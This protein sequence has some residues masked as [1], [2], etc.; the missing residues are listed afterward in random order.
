[1]TTL[2]ATIYRSLD[3]LRRRSGRPIRYLAA[4]GFNAALGLTFYP[5]LLWLFPYF[6]THYLVALLIA[7][8]T[9]TVI[10]FTVYKL[11][12]FRSQGNLIRE[13]GS[14]IVFYLLNYMVNWALL[15]VMVEYFHMSPIIAQW[16]FVILLAASSY[17]WHSRISFRLR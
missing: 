11:I 3:R 17:V 14:F 4:G 15:P 13:F 7:Q 10:A 12:V 1:M 2:R 16:L 5:A 6:R 8:V 9:C